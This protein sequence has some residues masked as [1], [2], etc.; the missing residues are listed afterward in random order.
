MAYKTKHI[1]GLSFVDETETAKNF[2]T[3]VNEALEGI[4]CLI[5]IKYS[6]MPHQE[7]EGEELFTALI[8]YNDKYEV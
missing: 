1:R 3:R 2:E 8:I 5:D 6:S 7:L 4:K